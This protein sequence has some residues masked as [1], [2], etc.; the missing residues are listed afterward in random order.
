VARCRSAAW[1]NARERSDEDGAHRLMLTAAPGA[2]VGVLLQNSFNVELLGVNI[3]LWAM[4]GVV[5]VVAFGGRTR[6]E[7]RASCG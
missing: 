1:R 5:S 4:A 6:A 7:S 3:V 2:I